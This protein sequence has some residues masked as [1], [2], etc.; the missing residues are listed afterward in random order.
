VGNTQQTFVHSLTGF[1]NGILN[2]D[3]GGNVTVNQGGFSGST[4][5]YIR[6]YIDHNRYIRLCDDLC[7]DQ[8][9]QSLATRLINHLY[10]F[11]YPILPFKNSP[12]GYF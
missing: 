9:W 10:Q 4:I 12:N 2:I 5:A 1:A 6:L 3:A 7:L 11:T 8:F